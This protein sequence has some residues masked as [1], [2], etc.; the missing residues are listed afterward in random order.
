MDVLKPLKLDKWETQGIKIH[1]NDGC[2]RRSLL[3]RRPV[4]V[5]VATRTSGTQPRQFQRSPQEY[6]A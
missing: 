5:R 2:L 1:W 3:I 6:A 4:G